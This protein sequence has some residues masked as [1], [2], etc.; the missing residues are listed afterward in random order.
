MPNHVHLIAA[1]PT[2]DALRAGIAEAHPR[3]A[4]RINFR[5]GW[6]SHLWEEFSI[7]QARCFRILPC[8]SVSDTLNYRTDLGKFHK[9]W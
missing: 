8:V 7:P 6:P 1:P 5:K 9:T 3:Y 2:E 4:R